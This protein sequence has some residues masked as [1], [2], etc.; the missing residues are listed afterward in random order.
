MVNYAFGAG[1]FKLGERVEILT[2]GQRGILVEEVVHL[3]GCNTYRVMLPNVTSEYD[4][5]IKMANI[6]YL[7]LRKL[8]PEE[9]VFL[10]DNSIMLADD[11]IFSPKGTDVNPTWIETAMKESKELI[12]EIDEAVGIEEIMIKPGMEVWHKIYNKIMLVNYVHRS[13]FSKELEYGLTYMAK[14]K[15][16]SVDSRYYALIPMEM[17]IDVYLEKKSGPLFDDSRIEIK[18][19]ISIDDFNRFPGGN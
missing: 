19:R 15:Q 4:G 6:D 9:A 5:S 3:S 17:K 10:N 2:T 18:Q 11:M 8:N 13:I 1:G 16:L 14:D 7:L 12:P